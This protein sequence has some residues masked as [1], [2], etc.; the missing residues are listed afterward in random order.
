M[1]RINLVS[2][3]AEPGLV[4]VNAAVSSAVVPSLRVTL[5]VYGAFVPVTGTFARL[6]A[7]VI[8]LNVSIVTLVAGYVGRAVGEISSTVIPC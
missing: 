4:T 6:K 2:S 7:A 8:W 5:T 3:W 1:G